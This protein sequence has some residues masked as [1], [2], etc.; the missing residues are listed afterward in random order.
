MLILASI[1]KNTPYRWPL[2]PGKY[3]IG[4]NPESEY[5]IN[6]TTISRRHAE[7]IADD[8]SIKLRDLG[9][10]NGTTVN[11]EK[12]NDFVYLNEN[13]EI[14]FG[15]VQFRILTDKPKSL[16]ENDDRSDEV[17][18]T[19]RFYCASWEPVSAIVT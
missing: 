3:I 6:D 8:S 13:D 2:L 14:W 7:I 9:S 10:H 11:G 19:Q 15:K 1:I 16:Y 5:F 12:I 18:L 4:R 17:D